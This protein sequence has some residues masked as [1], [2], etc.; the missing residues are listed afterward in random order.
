MANDVTYPSEPIVLL[1]G[2][3]C[4]RRIWA[5]QLRAFDGRHETIVPDISEA[6]SLVEM[7]KRT[8][9]EAPL[10][11]ALVGHSMGARVAL[12]IFR[13]A[14]ERVTRLALLDTGVHLPKPNEASDRYAL[15]A[16]GR[17]DGIEALTR[18]WL[19][20]MVAPANRRS[21]LMQSLRAMVFDAGLDCFERQIRALLGRPEVESLLPAID[22]PTLVGVGSQDTWSPPAQLRRIA[23]AIPGAQYAV[24]AGAGHM[25][26]V[27]APDAV[28]AALAQWFDQPSAG[29]ARQKSSERQ[30]KASR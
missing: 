23:Q 6:D 7:A 9:A 24:F 18:L 5:H 12:E 3:M 19:T 15:L 30:A 8:L 13:A 10:R 27:E 14:P 21:D 1:P 28:N 2:L 20:P 26:P 11:F 29:G 4:D 25:A 22:V 16:V 17:N